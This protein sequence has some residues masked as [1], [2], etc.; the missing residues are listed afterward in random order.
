MPP[1]AW[2]RW[3][4]VRVGGI[5]QAAANE[6]AAYD[7]QHAQACSGLISLLQQASLG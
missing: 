6:F 3:W 1:A 2:D 7:R 4:R 5:A